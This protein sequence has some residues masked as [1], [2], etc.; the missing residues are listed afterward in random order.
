LSVVPLLL[1]GLIASTNRAELT[2]SFC[3]NEEFF[4]LR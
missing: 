2:C 4:L 3:F 1:A